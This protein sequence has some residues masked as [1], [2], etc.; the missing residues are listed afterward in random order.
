M[1]VAFKW[2]PLSDNVHASFQS[3]TAAFAHP[4]GCAVLSGGASGSARPSL[5]SQMDGQRATAES[6]ID[7]VGDA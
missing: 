7:A 6:E 3:D 2:I 1:H 5:Y 4:V